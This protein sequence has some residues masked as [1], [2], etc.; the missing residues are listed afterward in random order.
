MIDPLRHP[1]P[2]RSPL[3]WTYSFDTLVAEGDSSPMYPRL[4]HFWFHETVHWL[5]HIGTSF[6]AFLTLAKYCRDR[7]AIHWFSQLNKNQSGHNILMRRVRE[8][9]PIVPIEPGSFKLGWE[10]VDEDIDVARQILYDLWW[11]RCTLYSGPYRCFLYKEPEDIL[12][13]G[14]RD[15]SNKFTGT[16]RVEQ[17][18]V[19]P[20]DAIFSGS[21]RLTATDLIEAA[22]MVNEYAFRLRSEEPL[23]DT[24]LALALRREHDPQSND[25]HYF[26]PVNFWCERF[27]ISEREFLCNSHYMFFFMLACDIALNPPLPPFEAINADAKASWRWD[28]IFPPARFARI[29][30]LGIGEHVTGGV[31]SLQD[32]MCAAAGLTAP[33]QLRLMNSRLWRSETEWMGAP[34]FSATRSDSYFHFFL[35][36]ATKAWEARRHSFCTLACPALCS[37]LKPVIDKRRLFIKKA[38]VFTE[39]F[40]NPPVVVSDGAM[41]LA[42]DGY[43]RGLATWLVESTAMDAPLFNLAFNARPPLDLSDFPALISSSEPFRRRLIRNLEEAVGISAWLR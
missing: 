1:P 20:C 41:Q 23:E 39:A 12:S 25:Y 7:S 8:G 3:H 33:S 19:G 14:L 24:L 38:G 4:G 21:Y 16:N 32:E 6:G 10:P 31:D 37:D 22:A 42:E 28:D 13:L 17:P 27:G 15:I 18:V 9:V 40:A 11:V 30:K 2:F 5:Q 29:V 43:S 34:E 36:A 35:W 26:G